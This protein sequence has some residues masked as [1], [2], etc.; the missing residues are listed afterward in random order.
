[1]QSTNI[2]V[3]GG[4]PA[5]YTMMAML[6]LALLLCYI[7]R[8]II[9]IAAI[10]M[11]KDFGWTDS[12]KGLVLSS[13]FLGYLIMQIMGGILSNRFGGRIVLLWAVVFW[14]LFTLLTPVVAMIS[15]QLLIVVRFMLGVGEGGSIPAA[16]GLIHERMPIRERS[17]AIS[18]MMASVSMGAIIALAV[19]GPIIEA[20]GWP[21]L[22][23]FFGA[24]GFVW[25]LFWVFL[26]PTKTASL[27]DTVE[28][29]RDVP[30]KETQKTSVK[31]LPWRLLFTHPAVLTLYL[32]AT[33]VGCITH[34]MSSWLPSYFAD[35]YGVSAARA[36]F[37]SILPF[38]GLAVATLLSGIYSDWRL[39]KNVERLRVRREVTV[40][41]A[42]LIVLGLSM[43]INSQ[44]W[45]LSVASASLAMAGLGGFVIGYM[46][47][48]GEVLPDH[49][50]VVFGFLAGISSVGGSLMIY[51]TGYIV[52]QTSSY[53]GVFYLMIGLIILS[54]LIYFRFAQAYPIDRPT[55][56][57]V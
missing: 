5:R 48:A 41:C 49:G 1:M 13:F 9:S 38:V 20:Y 10:E 27:V 50:D 15:F 25:G 46:P 3:S 54:V 52:D 53:S 36:G 28:E 14:S 47:L 7:D 6:V 23:Y 57:I 34:T 42:V 24:I 51:L 8:V 37:L 18:V 30:Q 55:A 44:Q 21:T 11:Q 29:D 22:F 33:A 4:W 35:S 17:R 31:N 2:T 56:A 12:E 16:Y 39:T 40:F 19:S 32:L 45:I 26:V 43:L